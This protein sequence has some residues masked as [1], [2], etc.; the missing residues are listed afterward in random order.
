[1]DYQKQTENSKNSENSAPIAGLGARKRMTL[2]AV[3]VAVFML[4]LD[5]TVVAV[6]LHNI[7][8]EL[9]ASYVDLQWVVNGYTLTFAAFLLAGGGLAD[10]V[11][12]RL[13]FL[14][15][16]ALFIISSLGCGFAP[17][18]LVLILARGIQGIGAA[19]MFSSAV[20]LLVQEFVEPGERARAFGVYGAVVGL[21]AGLGPFIGGTIISLAGWRWAFFV[22]VPVTLLA[23]GI[24][25]SFVRESKDS[26]AKGIDWA[27]TFTFTLANF[28]LIYGL[29][30][31]GSAG[32]TSPIILAVFSGALVLFALFVVIELRHDYPMF[33]LSLFK[34]T[35]FI[36]VSVPALVLSVAF[37][38]VF[39]FSPMYYQAA[40]GYTPLQA[41]LAV[42]PF[43]AP[44]FL[45][46]P[47]GGWLATRMTTA[48]LL[49]LG[50][51]LVGAG[52]FLLLF[53]AQSSGWRG[54]A[55]GGIVSGIGTGLINGQMTNAAMSIVPAERSGMA[56]G[57]NAT[58]RQVGVA[59]GF[60]GLGA[61]LS[62]ATG[63]ALEAATVDMHF[64]PHRMSALVASVVK[65]DV[66]EGARQLPALLQ[67]SFVSAAHTA[68]FKGLR[69]IAAIAGFVGIGG[70]ILTLFL[71]RQA[72][73]PEPAPA[74][75]V[76]QSLK[77]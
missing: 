18:A 31:G 68:L 48:H 12:R 35:T 27:G 39:L 53:A 56:S 28:L 11:G 13:V 14:I 46:G 42:L 61:V 74:L 7:Q 58:M 47:V 70:S 20:P 32:W 59:L 49:A 2:V 26:N 9:H 37:W 77:S 51:F 40:L 29:V 36:G 73:A 75:A 45:M 1:M 33:D 25:F 24:T 19:L 63:R 6:A 62:F 41:G 4:P 52:S 43:A 64:A 57:I 55:L 54:F 50:Q 69:T 30:S 8:S 21:G 76:N 38:G 5:Y 16:M 44:L 15:G 65:G 10:L 71:V 72:P 67:S 17:Q 22:N 34:N 3:A 66:A 23:A 60:A